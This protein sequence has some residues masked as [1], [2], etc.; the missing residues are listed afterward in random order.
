M[1]APFDAVLVTAGS[2]CQTGGM[3]F[4]LIRSFCAVL[5][6]VGGFSIRAQAQQVSPFAGGLGFFLS[7]DSLWSMP[8]AELPER[9]K[10]VGYTVD[11]ASGAIT[12]GEPRDMMKR[13]AH[14]FTADLPVWK[15]T[16]TKGTT[17]RS[18][19]LDFL[20][21]AS[22][23]K[24]P[25]KADFRSITR[26][27]EE[28]LTATLKSP[29]ELH[30]YPGTIY[31]GVKATS[32]RW[33]GKTIQVILVTSALETKTSFVPQ[34]LQL[35]LLPAIPPGKPSIT[36]APAA[37]VDR[38]SGVVV[39]EGVPALPEWEGS[40]P[41][42]VILEQALWSVGKNSDRNGIIECYSYGTGWMESF[43]SGIRRLTVMAGAKT[44]EISPM[45]HQP[46]ELARLLKNCDAAA[47]KLGKH[48]PESINNLVDIDPDVLRMAR[49]S[50]NALT[51]FTAALKQAVSGGRP[52]FWYGWRGIFDENPKP[53]GAP[54]PV[55]RLI[56]GYAPKEGELIFADASGKPGS[57]MKITDAL[58]A[59]LYTVDIS[60]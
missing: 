52:P 33:I 56:I 22:V 58:A 9:L 51:Q 7:E 30:P 17:L 21:P 26:R 12:L 8:A 35:S 29:P 44:V 38:V 23:A 43:V 31:P 2:R 54:T 47:K 20:P 13:Q 53:E 5:L 4:T 27:L 11:A 32:Q 15:A 16:L 28:H 6:L 36:K 60:K 55:V 49:T 24:T 25:A 42:W 37:K 19:L 39:L 10:S 14:L 41:A 46:A 3:L 45:I 50:G 59:S 18:V 1:T 57:R 40:H 34:S 48:S